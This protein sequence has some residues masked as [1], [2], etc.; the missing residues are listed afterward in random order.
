MAARVSKSKIQPNYRF[1]VMGEN[2]IFK[3]SRNFKA[4]HPY[5]AW[6]SPSMARQLQVP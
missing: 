5:K 6:F 4:R 2:K 3:F 1:V